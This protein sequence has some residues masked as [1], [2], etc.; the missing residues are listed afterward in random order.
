MAYEED[1]GSKVDQTHMRR[2]RHSRVGLVQ[3]LKYQ[4]VS[5]I[6]KIVLLVQQ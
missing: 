1:T 3:V 2:V 6:P 5:L 4:E